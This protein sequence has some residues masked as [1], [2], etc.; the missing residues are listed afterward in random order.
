MKNLNGINHLKGVFFP[1]RAHKVV[2]KAMYLSCMEVI[3]HDGG[4]IYVF[5]MF[6]V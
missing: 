5:V 3:E 2:L 1:C 4:A 6:G